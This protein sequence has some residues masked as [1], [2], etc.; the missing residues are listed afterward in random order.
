MKYMNVLLQNWE[1]PPFDCIKTADFEPAVRAAIAEAESA[2]EAIA[3]S[4][5][6]PT[7]E[8]T[9]EA[10]EAAS[11]RLDRVSAVMLNLNECCTDDELQAAVMRLEPRNHA[12][13]HAC[14]ARPQVVREG[15]GC[16]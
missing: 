11:R 6:P 15:E 12:V 5:E 2:V 1:L 3:A 13:H 10:L 4:P 16:C 7:F 8:N 14:D 9:V